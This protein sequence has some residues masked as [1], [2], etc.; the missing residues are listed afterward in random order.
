MDLFKRAEPTNT[1]A[2]GINAR[3]FVMCMHHIFEKPNMIKKR[4]S[5]T[6]NLRKLQKCSNSI[7]IIKFEEKKVM[8]TQNQISSGKN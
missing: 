8:K 3:K 1:K 6:E 4:F 5:V 2:N 7:L